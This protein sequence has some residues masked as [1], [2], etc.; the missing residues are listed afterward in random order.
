ML[1]CWPLWI[2]IITKLIA[3]YYLSCCRCETASFVGVECL[4]HACLRTGFGYQEIVLKHIWTWSQRICFWYTYLRSSIG[5]ILNKPRLCF[6]HMTLW[7]YL[8]I[9]IVESGGCGVGVCI[10]VA[11]LIIFRE[12][13]TVLV[14][15][16]TITLDAVYWS[17]AIGEL[18]SQMLFTTWLIKSVCSTVS[19]W[20]SASSI[21]VIGICVVFSELTHIYY[22]RLAIN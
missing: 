13:D 8:F 21:Y 11:I 20:F 17:T 22:T 14:L 1:V 4:H 15:C 16:L 6:I 2:R 19:S 10:E 5:H 7:R 9:R 18:S 3:A 12:V